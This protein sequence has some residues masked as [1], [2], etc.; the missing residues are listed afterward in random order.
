MMR[1]GGNGLPGRGFATIRL[2]TIT[3]TDEPEPFHRIQRWLAALRHRLDRTAASE[4]AWGVVIALV[5]AALTSLLLAALLGAGPGRWAWI[6][7]GLAL[8]V[9]VIGAWRI[10]WIPRR[11]RRCDEGLARWVEARVDGLHSGVITAVQVAEAVR[12]GDPWPG[13]SLPM[14][15]A[16]ASRTHERL[17]AA[18]GLVDRTTLVRLRRFGLL[19]L[20]VGS[21]AGVAS[22]DLLREGATNLIAPAPAEAAVSMTEVDVAVGDIAFRLVYPAYLDL[23]P[24]EI[25]RSS[26]DVSAVSGT[27]VALTASTLMPAVAAA[28][29]LESDPEGR[30]PVELSAD[31]VVRATFRVGSSDRYRFAL[32]GFDGG[33]I[34]ERAWRHIEAVPDAAPDVRLLLPETDMEVD[35]SDEVSFV[36]EVVDDHGLDRVELVVDPLDGGE[37]T[38]HG[39]RPVYGERTARLTTALSI[40]PL[41][42]RPG[43]AV[44]VWVEAADLNT[45]TGPGVGRSARRRI[46]MYSPEAEHDERVVDLERLIEHMIDVLAE[47]LE[48][49]VD[50]RQPSKLATYLTIH[51]A[52]S[53]ASVSMIERGEQLAIALTSDSMASDGLREAVRTI[54]ERLRD[55]HDQE[56]AQLRMA[57]D[58]VKKLR[59]MPELTEIL[60]G[61]NEEGSGELE[62]GV[63]TLKD[64]LDESRRERLLD[65]GRELLEAQ[66]ELMELMKE[67]KAGDPEAAR[68]AERMMDQLEENLRRM[69]QE[70][71]KMAERTP[72]ENQNMQPP[73]PS[74][75]QVDVRSLR[76][77]MAEVRKL[78]REGRMDEA[79]KLLEELNRET[80]EM[81]AA[82]QDDY[83]PRNKL[84]AETKQRLTDFTMRQQ[85]IADG[86]Q[87]LMDETSEADRKMN[88]RQRREMAEKMAEA[89]DAAQDKAKQIEE[90]LSKADSDPL[91]PADKEELSELADKAKNLRESVERQD[92]EQAKEQAKKLGG[93]C[94]KLGGEVG[95][96]ESRELDLKRAKGLKGSRQ[97]IEAGGDLAEELAQ[98]LDDL[99]DKLNQA[100]SAEER[101]KSD[102]LG[103]RQQS[104]G[105]ELG[106]LDEDLQS[107]D[108]QLPGI[109]E[110]VGPKL[111]EA[112]QEMKSAEEKLGQSKPG[113][114][115]RHQRAALDRLGEARKQIERRMK[116]SQDSKG[117]DGVGI[118]DPKRRVEI[119]EGADDRAKEAFRE[120]LLKAMKERAPERFKP[121][122]DRYYEELIR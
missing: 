54:F 78:M 108:E 110:Q 73:E 75:G 59:R 57:F 20:V 60:F 42:L 102:Q 100:P 25:P 64:L 99:L 55:H 71:A 82:L 97:E 14:A 81:M 40:A 79:M 28:L 105:K 45:V 36:V 95:A 96:S 47:R 63:L 6:P 116:Q 8:I 52:I 91:H 109:K 61:V 46:S 84:A 53:Q 1:R 7:L 17:A 9:S 38:R 114:A 58:A 13:L 111:G 121:A 115:R 15:R 70:L 5:P 68:E 117:R 122:I 69:E 23:Q 56:A 66:N 90:K 87:G 48:S 27:E 31:G 50:E 85:E 86:Q 34:A 104:L 39:T 119:P 83:A 93:Q 22:V 112:G 32:T 98:D 11:Q 33:V 51:Q 120:E 4:V 2:N 29:V 74:D 19:V 16:A 101:R 21:L 92:L 89:L 94:N 44:D 77:R 106:A 67:M 10:W 41:D 65:E 103:Q 43:E 80:Q 76:D 37:I 118:N 62:T 49:P 30:W 72:Y 18:D 12:T 3:A 88:E 107:L 26:G 113:E 24:R 35:P